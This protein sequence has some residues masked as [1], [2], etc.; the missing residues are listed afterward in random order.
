[1]IKGGVLIPWV[2]LSFAHGEEELKLTLQAT[3]KALQVYKKAL[4]EGIEKYLVG[5]AIKPVFRKYN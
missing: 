5:K 3:E 4:D 1:M 2:A